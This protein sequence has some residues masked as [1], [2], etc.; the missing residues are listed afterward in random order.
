MVPDHC[1]PINSLPASKRCAFNLKSPN[2]AAGSRSYDPANSNVGAASSH[3]CAQRSPA[4]DARKISKA[5]F[6]SLTSESDLNLSLRF[7]F[8]ASPLKFVGQ[9]WCR[10]YFRKMYCRNIPGTFAERFVRYPCRP[11]GR[12]HIYGE[13]WLLESGTEP[14]RSSHVSEWP[15]D[16]GQQA[17]Y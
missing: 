1:C 8:T 16:P 6:M 17:E 11:D 10:I 15:R 14:P 2:I 3:E 13:C 9:Q 4:V 12:Q 5:R 7:R